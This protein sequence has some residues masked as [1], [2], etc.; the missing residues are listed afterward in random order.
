LPLLLLLLGANKTNN[1]RLGF[2]LFVRG[3]AALDL[4]PD[5]PPEDAFP[6][7]NS[8][9]TQGKLKEHSVNIQDVKVL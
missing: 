8:G 5:Q 3:M 4:A 9:N 7:C 1:F 2:R 6:R